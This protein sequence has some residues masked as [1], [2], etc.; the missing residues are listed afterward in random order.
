MQEEKEEL[1]YAEEEPDIGFLTTAYTRT[2]RD[3]DTFFFQCRQNYEDRRCMWQGKSEDLRKNAPDAF[4]WQGASDQEAQIIGERVDTYVALFMQAL[5]RSHIKAF[6]TKMEAMPRAAV[7]SAFLKY[8]MAT[9]IRGFYSEMERCANF[10]LEKG[11]MVSYVGWQK[12]SRTFLQ[13]MS[14]EEIGQ[15]A[16]ELVDIINGGEDDEALAGLLQQMFPGLSTKRAKRGIKDL[17][18]KGTATLSVSRLSVNRPTVEACLP[19]GEVFFPSW[20]SDAQRAPYVFWRKLMTAQ[21]IEKKVTASGWDR[22]WAEYVIEHLG[23]QGTQELLV[24][25]E[26]LTRSTNHHP[27]T[28]SDNQELYLVVF[29]YQRLIDEDDG[30]EGIYCTA[31]SPF[32]DG[33]SEPGTQPYAKRELLNGYDDYPFVVTKVQEDNKRLYDT[34]AIPEKLRGIQWE[35]KA[36]RDA[37]IDRAGLTTCPPREGPLGKAPPD[38]G[39]GRYIGVRRRGE[40]GYVEIPRGDATSNEV[41]LTL[42]AQAD[43][44]VGLDYNIPNAPIRQQFYVDKMLEHAKEVLKMAYKAFQRFGPDEVFFNVTGFPDPVT[45]DNIDEEDFNITINFDT[46][47]NDP[48]TMKARAEQMASLMQFDTSGRLDKGKFMEFIAMSIDPAFADYILLPAEENQQ[49][50]AKEITTDLTKIF[51]GIEVPAQP[52]GA[53]FAMQLI[54][55]YAQ[56]PDIAQRLQGDDAFATRL[57]KYAEQYQFQLQQAQ[58]AQVGRIGTAP[59]QMGG[60]QTQGMNQ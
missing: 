17:R 6:P 21:E 55:A 11:L 38:W 52:N 50:M 60:V 41:E 39:P 53:Q 56:Q 54:Q 8:M 35:V 57:R 31:F 28:F 13:D 14:L 34:V 44:I 22:D 5:K 42:L 59:A 10:G 58:N 1:I 26:Y 24:D 18:D 27:T 46:L 4:P 12:E 37:R 3:L 19:D 48:E 40:V 51:S 9:Y 47:S 29:A 25:S 30:S 33:A 43:K 23:G 36:Q 2:I 20:C 7:V 49:K 16:P 15:M 45:I 32:F